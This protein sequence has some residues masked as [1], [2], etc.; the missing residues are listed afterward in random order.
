MPLNEPE[1]TTDATPGHVASTE[2][3]GIT[4]ASGFQ[5]RKRGAFNDEAHRNLMEAI[6]VAPD[7][8]MSTV[9]VWHACSLPKPNFGLARKW[10]REIADSGIGCERIGGSCGPQFY[11]WLD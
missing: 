8:P 4:L 2:G 1:Q 9:N 10:L 6:P 7:A 11:R 3:L 5:R